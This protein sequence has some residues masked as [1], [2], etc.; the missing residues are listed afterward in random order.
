MRRISLFTMY[1]KTDGDIVKL[2]NSKGL[3]LIGGTAI[4]IWMNH[5]RLPKS[6]IR[7]KNDFDF[8]SPKVNNGEVI[9]EL[10]RRGF[11]I[12][13]T[14]AGITTLK[15]SDT[16][17]DI[18]VDTNIKASH[19]TNVRG[20]QLVLPVYLFISK[21]NRYRSLILRAARD[22]YAKVKVQRDESDLIDLL[23]IMN[24]RGDS[25]ILLLESELPKLLKVDDQDLSYLQD[26][27]DKYNQLHH[28]RSGD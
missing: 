21:F 16:E 23:S 11:K 5:Y 22:E 26:I 27:V 4:E 19:I 20:I 17:V 14:D 8:I 1:E 3:S 24:H 2:G 28:S 25:D 12:T 7:S 10:T 18:L 6:R 9:E 13:S 15:S